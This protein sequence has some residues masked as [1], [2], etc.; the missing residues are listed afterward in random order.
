MDPHRPADPLPV[1]D[2]DGS[3][4][5]VPLS[6]LRVANLSEPG[7]AGDYRDD[8]SSSVT[9]TTSPSTVASTNP[10]SGAEELS[11][12]DA[13]IAAAAAQ[14]V[15]DANEALRVARLAIAAAAAV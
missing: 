6:A 9:C 11:V 7:S 10:S 3:A 8:A 12:A 4:T 13:D 5:V 2:D 15:C 1:P 14:D